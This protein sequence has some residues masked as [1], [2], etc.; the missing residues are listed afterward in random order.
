MAS[1][2]SSKALSYPEASLPTYTHLFGGKST[3]SPLSMAA[4]ARPKKKYLQQ[5]LPGRGRGELQAS[6]V[7]TQNALSQRS[8]INNGL[9][10]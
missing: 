7:E 5:R 8:K 9:W 3:L 1:F 4:A 6:Q 10:E 2:P